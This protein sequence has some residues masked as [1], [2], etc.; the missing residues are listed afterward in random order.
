MDGRHVVNVCLE[1]CWI[2]GA[3]SRAVELSDGTGR[4]ETWVN[5]A[6]VVGSAR[7]TEFLTARP[8]TPEEL[9]EAGIPS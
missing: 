5:G 2:D 4:I 1:P 6:W 8:A 9:A 3:I 7:W